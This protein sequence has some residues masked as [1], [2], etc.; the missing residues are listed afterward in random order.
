MGSHASMLPTLYVIVDFVFTI[1]SLIAC[2]VYVLQSYTNQDS[3]P[4]YVQ[5]LNIMDLGITT[6]FMFDYGVKMY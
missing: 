6:I 1:L 4:S 2:L 5:L 3:D